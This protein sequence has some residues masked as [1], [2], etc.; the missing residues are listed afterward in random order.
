MTEPE[1]PTRARSVVRVG[2]T[3]VQHGSG[4]T[5]NGNACCQISAPGVM[6]EMVQ[7]AS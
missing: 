2:G 1:Q 3:V 7:P 6:V 5:Y 4:C